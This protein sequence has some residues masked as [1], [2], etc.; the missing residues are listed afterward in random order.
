DCRVHCRDGG[1]VAAR[2]WGHYS[3]VPDARAKRRSYQRG[4]R[5]PGDSANDGFALVYSNGGCMPKVRADYEHLLP[6]ARTEDSDPYSPLDAAVAPRISG[7]GGHD[8]RSN[9][10]C[11]EWTW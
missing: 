5:G 3:S 2:H 7:C 10:L 11:G 1:A 6:G 4:D 9:G 8:G